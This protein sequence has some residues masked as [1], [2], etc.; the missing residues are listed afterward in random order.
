[1]LAL[2]GLVLP[3]VWLFDVALLNFLLLHRLLPVALAVMVLL[4]YCGNLIGAVAIGELA[5]AGVAAAIGV[6]AIAFGGVRGAPAFADV[7]VANSV[8][9]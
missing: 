1:M 8:I 5:N 2:D 7:S 6:S 3:A 4:V 9:V